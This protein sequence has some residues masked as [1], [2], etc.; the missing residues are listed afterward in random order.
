MPVWV[1]IEDTRQK[2]GQKNPVYAFRTVQCR[3]PVRFSLAWPHVP[4]ILTTNVKRVIGLNGLTHLC[5]ERPFS[6]SG[7]LP[8]TP[9]I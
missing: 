8:R 1:S 4:A 7:L 5:C 9:V 3:W 6:T 2:Q